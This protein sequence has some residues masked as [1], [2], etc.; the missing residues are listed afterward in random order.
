M[1]QRQKK[2]RSEGER[3]LEENGDG[4]RSNKQDVRILVAGGWRRAKLLL[5]HPGSRHGTRGQGARALRRCAGL[6]DRGPLRDELGQRG[7]F[8]LDLMAQINSGELH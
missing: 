3:E 5:I 4:R 8:D 2:E 6:L 1:G 7:S